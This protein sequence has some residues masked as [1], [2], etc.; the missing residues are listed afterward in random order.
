MASLACGAGHAAEL[1]R[2]RQDAFVLVGRGEAGGL[3]LLA[4]GLDHHLDGQIILLG[5]L[6][7]PLVVGRH[8]HHRAGAV[9]HE[10]EIGHVNGHLD[11]GDRVRAKTAGEHPLLGDLLQDAPAAV[12]GPPVVHEVPHRLFLAGALG[13]RQGQGMLRGQAHEG[14]PEQGV[15][16][17]GEHRQGLAACPPGENRSRPRGICRSSGAAWSGPA[18][19]S[20]SAGPGR[21]KVPRH[22]R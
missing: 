10:H 2:V 12:L 14:G 16:P 18:P 11:A 8:R 4:G 9:L 22:N 19:A 21:P 13:Q 15:G 17:G 1:A 3:Q 5:E 20:G 6:E 7:I